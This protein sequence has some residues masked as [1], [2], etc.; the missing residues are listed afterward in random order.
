MN[1]T[2]ES[3]IQSTTESTDV[4]TSEVYKEAFRVTTD[5]INQEIQMLLEAESAGE[6]FA[7]ES[8]AG[9]SNTLQTTTKKTILNSDECRQDETC[10]ARPKAKLSS[11]IDEKY[12]SQHNAI[13]IPISPAFVV[14][15][16]PSTGE[17]KPG[18]DQLSNTPYLAKQNHTNQNFSAD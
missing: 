1:P 18:K 2:N 12:I 15:E 17:E 14:N 10:F 5:L 3:N 11:N 9:S 7:N 16:D 4:T 8:E 13:Q 6:D